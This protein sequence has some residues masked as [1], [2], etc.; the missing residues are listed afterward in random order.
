MATQPTPLVAGALRLTSGGDPRRTAAYAAG[1]FTVQGDGSMVV[2][3]AARP[4]A[5]ARVLDLCAGVG[6]KATHMAELMDNQGQVLAVDRQGWKLAR[7]K[8][9]CARLG[10]TIVETREQDARALE[11]VG[12]YDL[13]LVDAP[14]SGTGALRRRADSRW[15]KTPQQIA[16]LAALQGELLATALTLVR[17]QGVVVYSTCSLE[18]EENEGVVSAALADGRACAEDCRG[19]VAGLPD[20][21]LAADGRALRLLPHLHDADGMFIARLR[22]RA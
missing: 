8:E 4:R 1:R 21:A 20:S 22:R 17:P 13:C 10:V 18:P 16:K 19:L 7:L 11:G 6:G 14:C 5:G 9:E 15:R 2:G 12:G 3:L